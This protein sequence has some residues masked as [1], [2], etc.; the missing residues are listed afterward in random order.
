M[1]TL[2]IVLKLKPMLTLL[3]TA[4]MLNMTLRQLNYRLKILGIDNVR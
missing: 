1:P 3:I 4:Q 2:L